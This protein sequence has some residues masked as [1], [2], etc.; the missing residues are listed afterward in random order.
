M[1]CIA[2]SP[3]RKHQILTGSYSQSVFQ[4]DTR[5]LRQPLQTSQVRPV[6]LHR[7]LAKNPDDKVRRYLVYLQYWTHNLNPMMVYHKALFPPSFIINQEKRC[8][9]GADCHPELKLPPQLKQMLMHLF[10]EL[11]LWLKDAL[12]TEEWTPGLSKSRGRP[13][14]EGFIGL[15][16][17][18][19]GIRV[20]GLLTAQVRTGGGVWRLK[21]HPFDARY[22]L[23]ACM[24]GGFAGAS[25][26][27]FHN[28]SIAACD[29]TALSVSKQA[30]HRL[31]S[32]FA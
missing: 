23:A 17:T 6:L 5:Q 13:L 15:G 27:Q 4:W 16:L 31:K 28:S 2:P 19:L 10:P 29:G 14:P 21:W 32:R 22:L 7:L 25:Q 9:L 1:C 8:Q 3:H 20:Y 30:L 24:Q 12:Q 18:D 11:Q 26:Q